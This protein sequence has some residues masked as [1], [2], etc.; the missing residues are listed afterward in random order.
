[1]SDFKRYGSS[2]G[3]NSAS[4]KTTSDAH[5]Y[6]STTGPSA[7]TVD[8]H[9]H[10]HKEHKHKHK[11]HKEHKEHKV[12]KEH[13]EHKHKEKPGFFDKLL[14]GIREN[15]K[16]KTIE[17]QVDGSHHHHHTTH[18]HP[19]TVTT[20]STH[21]HTTHS[22]HHHHPSSSSTKIATHDTGFRKTG[23]SVGPGCEPKPV[24]KV[25][26]THHHVSVSPS[27]SN[28]CSNCGTKVPSVQSNF[29]V[30]CGRRV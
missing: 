6:V 22:H 15:P 16:P 19:H 7:I 30:Q 1:M 28:F 26:V 14:D 8:K 17:Q 11:E 2:V 25:V 23:S 20:H 18:S 10:K 21:H 9:H 3:A 27:H 12:H 29:C 13:K 5:L 24:T 4:G